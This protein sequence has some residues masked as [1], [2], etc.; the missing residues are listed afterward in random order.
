[1]DPHTQQSILDA[2]AE[3]GRENVVVLLGS[4]SP[5][6]AATAAETVTTGDPTFAGPLTETRLGLP[7]YHILENRVR[8]ALDPQLYDE[9]VGLMAETLDADAIVAAVEN[10]RSTGP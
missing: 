7:V 10:V 3:Y 8:E 5:E 2:V 9:Q 1:V 4:P 6:A